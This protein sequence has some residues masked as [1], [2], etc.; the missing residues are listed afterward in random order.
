MNSENKDL[1]LHFMEQIWNRQQFQELPGLLHPAFEDHSLPPSF[2]ANAAG[3]Q[4]WIEATGQSFRHHSKID[5]MVSEGNTVM[6]KFTMELEHTGAWRE[7]EPT[8]AFVYAVGYRCFEIEEGKI[9]AHWALL[10][11]NAIENQLRQTTHGCK[12]Q[13]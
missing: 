8:G 10:D 12:V 9:R 2:P 3:L 11:G 13:R 1:I 7:I 5:Q 6:I 4:Q